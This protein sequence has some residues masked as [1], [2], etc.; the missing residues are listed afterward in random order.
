MNHKPVTLTALRRMKAEGRPIAM[1]TAYDAS[2]AHHA[3]AAGADVLLVGDSL[4]MV[5]Q[6]HPDTLPVTVDDIVYHARAVARGSRRA[7]RVADMPFLS[8]ADPAGALATAARLLKE[9]GAQ[10]VKLEGGG[11]AD[12][13]GALAD[14]G[15]PVCAHLGL[16]PQMVHKLG[17][18][19]VQGRDQE[20]AERMLADARELEAAGADLLIL[21]CVP[22]TLAARITAALDIPVIGIGA[23]AEVDGQVLVSHDVLGLTPGR[24]PRFAANFLRGADDIPAALADYVAA[25]RERRFPADEHGFD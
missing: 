23:G 17:G 21:E 4:G 13:V 20:A 5:V 1:L 11:Q 15:V 3:E 14:H 7:L 16:Q 2:V 12:V 10:M 6:G 9:G 25:V 22:R 8:H 18:Y 19:R 24:P